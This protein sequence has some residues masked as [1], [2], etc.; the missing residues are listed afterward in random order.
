[1]QI[2]AATVA[3]VPMEIGAV[4]V[5]TVSAGT[6]EV[7]P[8][9]TVSDAMIGVGSART[10]SAVP[11][12]VGHAPM[13]NAETT[14]AEAVHR[15]VARL[16]TAG[17]PVRTGSDVMIEAV[18]VP[19]SG[20]MIGAVSAPPAIETNGVPTATAVPTAGTGVHT[21]RATTAEG[22]DPT[23]DEMTGAHKDPRVMTGGPAIVLSGA[24]TARG[25]SRGPTA[26]EV[27]SRGVPPET[28]VP[29]GVHTAKVEDRAVA[30]A[31]TGAASVRTAEAATDAARATGVR[32]GSAA[33]VVQDATTAGR[34]GTIGCLARTVPAATRR[35][36]SGSRRRP[37]LLR[38]RTSR[39]R[40]RVWT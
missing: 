36:A 30:G 35:P 4:R 13:E 19:T 1:M 23:S 15:T 18:R 12:A 3:H 2:G 16:P 24:P 34:A 9:P 37:G 6:I 40:P 25:V 20:V 39:R 38:V 28:E 32:T 17:A 21:A 22:G 14:A 5:P 29:N 7:V 10:A 26:T 31:T 33:R 8:V 27:V 11:I